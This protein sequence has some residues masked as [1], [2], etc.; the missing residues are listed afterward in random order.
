MGCRTTLQTVAR[1]KLE[2]GKD[3]KSIDLL[4]FL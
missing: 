1:P 4:S 3:S 2:L